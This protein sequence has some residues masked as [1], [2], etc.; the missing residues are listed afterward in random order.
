[1]SD[2]HWIPCCHWRADFIDLTE[3]RVE[4][5]ILQAAEEPPEKEI[6]IVL[7][8]GQTIELENGE[9]IAHEKRLNLLRISLQKTQLW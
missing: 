8:P 1:L 3:G 7:T 6:H 5:P 9:L 4:S 2:F